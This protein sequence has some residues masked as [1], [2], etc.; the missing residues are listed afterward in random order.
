MLVG[1]LIVVLLPLGDL[2]NTAL[3]LWQ[4]ELVVVLFLI[5]DV[6]LELLASLILWKFWHKSPTLRQSDLVFLHF[7][8]V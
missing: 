6:R 7:I 4:S 5:I 2:W 1:H 8:Q 3:A